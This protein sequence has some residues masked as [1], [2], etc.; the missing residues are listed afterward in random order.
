[1]GILIAIDGVDASG[2]QTQTDLLCD[3]L[4]KDGY[5]IR[6][7][8]FPVYDS[9]SSSVVKM[10]L[11]GE[12]GESA[13]DVSP[14][15]AS[16]FFA[17]D[18]YATF[19]TDWHTDYEND[20]VIICDRYVSSNMIHQ[21]AKLESDMEKEKFLNWL[22]DLEYEIY[23]IPMPTAT[24]FLDM[25]TK[26]SRELMLNRANKIDG[27]EVKDIHERDPKHLEKSYNNAVYVAQKYD[28][29]TISC[30]S[31]EKIRSIEDIHNEI[32]TAVKKLL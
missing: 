18:R 31:D 6:K 27:S 28:W 15:V 11:G 30:I 4:I 7:L 20:T 21:V 5:K 9:P 24:I 2:K 12:F 8:S 22:Y 16:T 13:D 1:M 25:P 17:V 32:Y 26:F 14:Y 10:Y 29:N 3:R 19:K 23:N